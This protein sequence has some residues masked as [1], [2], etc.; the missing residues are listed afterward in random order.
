MNLEENVVSYASSVGGLNLFVVGRVE[1]ISVVVSQSV[2]ARKAIAGDRRPSVAAV[3][4]YE[5]SLV[6]R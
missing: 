2:V 3:A 6:L 4:E 5:P 1:S